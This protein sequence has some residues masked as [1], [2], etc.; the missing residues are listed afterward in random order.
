MKVF[1]STDKIH[2]LC[3]IDLF[4]ICVKEKKGKRLRRFFSIRTYVNILPM[5]Q[6]EITIRALS[7]SHCVCVI[8]QSCT[9][10]VLNEET[11]QSLTRGD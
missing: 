8:S 7:S 4:H 1:Q 5:F 11:E 9:Q 6:L 2:V 3:R 10:T